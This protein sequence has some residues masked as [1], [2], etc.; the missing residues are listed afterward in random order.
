M[1]MST[2]FR[3][4]CSVLFVNESIISVVQRFSNKDIKIGGIGYLEHFSHYLLVT[5]NKEL[6]AELIIKVTPPNIL[7]KMLQSEP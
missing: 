7:V 2:N 3:N 1:S 4:V 5:I 6:F